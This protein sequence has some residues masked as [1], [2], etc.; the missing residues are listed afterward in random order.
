[1]KRFK[2]LRTL[3]LLII[4]LGLVAA[5]SGCVFPFGN[6]GPQP[7]RDGDTIVDKDDQCPNLWS[8]GGGV[9]GSGCPQGANADTDGD[10]FADNADICPTYG[11]PGTADGCPNGK[12]ADA[13]GDGVRDD[14]DQCP[15]QLGVIDAS[16]R[17]GCSG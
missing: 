8:Q 3:T 7:D 6:R 11:G 15:D 10:G 2:A 14:L 17:P 5:L 4:G 12:D 13:D 1:M 16:Q 9:E